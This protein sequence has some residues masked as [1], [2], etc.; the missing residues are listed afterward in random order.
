MRPRFSGDNAVNGVLAYAEGQSD[1][2]LRQAPIRQ[3]ANLA[4]V[5][6]GE[7][8]VHMRC[9]AKDRLSPFFLPINGVVPMR[10]LKQMGRVAAGRVVAGV[11]NAMFWPTVMREKERESMGQL[12]RV[13][14][15]DLTVSGRG[16]RAEPRPTGIWPAGF[17]NSIPDFLRGILRVWHCLA[18]Y[19]GWAIHRAGGVSAP[20]GVSVSIA[21][22]FVNDLARSYR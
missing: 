3:A 8:G 5:G 4:H 2:L 15:P 10:S 12:R 19:T 16:T 17:I 9:S 1:L 7:L 11:T 14:E 13:V 6:L 18:S 22:Q 20:P 21:D